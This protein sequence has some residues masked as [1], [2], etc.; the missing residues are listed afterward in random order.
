MPFHK[1]CIHEMND[2]QASGGNCFGCAVEKN[3]CEC[4]CSCVRCVGGGGGGGS[5]GYVPEDMCAYCVTRHILHD[6]KEMGRLA[7]HDLVFD[8]TNRAL[9]LAIEKMVDD[10]HGGH[11]P[12]AWEVLCEVRN[13]LAFPGRRQH[14]PS[15]GLVYGSEGCPCVLQVLG[16]LLSPH[17]KPSAAQLFADAHRRMDTLHAAHYAARDSRAELERVTEELRER[18]QVLAEQQR[19]NGEALGHARAFWAGPSPYDMEVEEGDGGEEGG[20]GGGEEAE[21]LE[22]GGEEQQ[23]E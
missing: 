3:E 23:G 18:E 4:A 8:A 9:S 13:V 14:R 5:C 7:S 11:A 21:R 12:W 2:G 1:N 15:C 19:L 20:G 16:Q 17:M 22:G 6:K 10:P